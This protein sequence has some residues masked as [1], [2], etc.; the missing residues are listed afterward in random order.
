MKT[1]YFIIF[2]FFTAN[3]F[4]QCPI[5]SEIE[6][7]TPVAIDNIIEICTGDSVTFNAV[8]DPTYSYEWDFGSLGIQTGQ[9]VTQQFNNSGGYLVR[10][11]TTN[12]TSCSLTSSDL[13][14]IVIFEQDTIECIKSFNQICLGDS[15]TINRTNEPQTVCNE[16]NA[17]APQTFLPDGNGVS[18]ETGKIIECFPQGAVLNNTSSFLGVCVNIEHSYLGDL[19]LELIAPDGTVLSLLN[20]PN[21]GGGTY[22]GEPIDVDSDNSPGRGY[23][24]C[25]TT[26]AT[27]AIDNIGLPTVP[28]GDYSTSDPFS[29]LS[30]VPLNGLWKLRITDNLA[31]DNGYIFD[32]FMQFGA[33]LD[34]TNN[35]D[36]SQTNNEFWSTH[37]DVN[38]QSNDE[39]L[40]TPSAVGINC[41][42]YLSI[43]PN[44]IS[45]LEQLCIEVLDPQTDFQAVDLYIYDS[46]A[47]GTED[48]N[49][50][51]NTDRLV[52]NMNP[53]TTVIDYYTTIA[54][55]QTQ[56]NPISNTDSFANTTNPQTIYASVN[57]S[58]LL[59]QGVIVEFELFLTNQ[60]VIDSDNDTIPDLSEDI[61]GNGD[62]TDDDTD[63][64]GVPN[65]LDDDDD[66][67]GVPTALETNGVGARGANI[68]FLDTD[69]D[70]IE[71]YL[72]ND[73]D[74]DGVLT[75]NEDYNGN[76][77]PTDDDTDGSGIPDFLENNVTLSIE[78][79]LSNN[80]VI[81]PNPF[82]ENSFEISYSNINSNK[83]KVELY[84]L[85]GASVLTQSYEISASGT[86]RIET[87]N[88]SSG[89][90]FLQL[91]T[92]QKSIY[93]LI[94]K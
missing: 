84:S 2:A 45:S 39:I 87:P 9:S 61:N 12:Q 4:G 34:S 35:Y 41:Y 36:S 47:N 18:Y 44:G 42:N 28:S 8:S 55:A 37:P 91:D 17:I 3:A 50:D 24:Y 67:D 78:S 88:L 38:V 56:S 66:G 58:N 89:I 63:G 79:L 21:Q 76:G 94:K 7:T 1:I 31:S 46:D 49:L 33:G 93:K 13:L 85:N 25:F 16:A 92:D 69:G 48:F 68:T 80:I 70:G 81:Y 72:D 65:Y 32:W 82:Y 43:N 15:V 59:C 29:N 5:L 27:Q 75:I 26:A 10:L 52:G 53:T 54:D 20:Y 23:E 90:Y 64:D 22:L 51:F 62:L 73:D 14:S 60:P 74:G 83:L 86:I 11:T 30:G 40:I 19:R 71:N 57:N 77:D 6:S